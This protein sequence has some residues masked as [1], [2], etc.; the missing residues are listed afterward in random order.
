MTEDQKIE[1]TEAYKFSMRL[2]GARRPE[3]AALAV[4]IVFQQSLESGFYAWMRSIK[5][6]N[7]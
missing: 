1:W 5:L 2:V 3:T 4:A 7:R 6:V